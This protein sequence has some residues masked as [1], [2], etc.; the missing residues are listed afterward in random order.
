MTLKTFLMLT[1]FAL[2]DLKSTSQ[3]IVLLFIF[4]FAELGFVFQGGTFIEGGLLF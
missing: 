1:R 3:G 4:I 2:Y